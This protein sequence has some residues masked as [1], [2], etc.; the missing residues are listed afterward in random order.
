MEMV[1]YNTTPTMYSPQ[2]AGLFS[3]KSRILMNRTQKRLRAGHPKSGGESG[4]ALLL[5]IFMVATLFLFAAAA[6]PNVVT[7]G[8]RLK[9]EEMIWRGNQYVRAVRLFYAKN[10]RYPQSLEELTKPN[11]ANVHFLRKVYGEPINTADGSW[12]LIYVSPTGQLIGSV[13]YRTLQEMA[14]AYAFGGQLGGG[15]SAMAAQLF[16]QPI[17][18]GTTGRPVG[19]GTPG[20]NPS[21]GIAS[22]AQSTPD[23]GLGAVDGPVFGGSVIGVASKVKKPSISVYQGGTTYFEW[24]FIWNPLLSAIPGQIP[25]GPPTPGAPGVSLPG[26]INPPATTAPPQPSPTP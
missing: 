5:V 23:G 4:Y 14:V 12:R 19:Q 15:A 20:Q 10:G 9:E 3:F 17:S 2:A 24:E 6:N 7:Q 25:A 21:Q 11:A 26:P 16:G 8:R 18:P 22:A 13:H 1:W